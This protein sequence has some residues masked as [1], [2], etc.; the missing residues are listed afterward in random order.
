MQSIK[1]IVSVILTGLMLSNFCVAGAE[2][3]EQVISL[4][5]VQDG[6]ITDTYNN[7]LTSYGS[8]TPRVMTAM[9]GD[10][11]VVDSTG[12]IEIDGTNVADANE[13]TFETWISINSNEKST[14]RRLLAIRDLEESSSMS[15]VL[16]SYT[17]SSNTAVL[18]NKLGTK[19]DP[20][21][22]AD[23]WI[24][25]ST[26]DI[27]QY[28]GTWRHYVFTRK[29][30]SV[31]SKW[32]TKTYVNGVLASS[33]EEIGTK[34][35]EDGCKLYLGSNTTSVTGLS[36][37]LRCSY[38]AFNVYKKELSAERIAELYNSTKNNYRVPANDMTVETVTPAAGN[39]STEAGK[40]TIKFS[41]FIEPSTLSGNIVFTKENGGTVEGWSASVRDDIFVDITIPKLQHREKY[42]VSVKSGLKSLNQIAATEREFVFTAQKAGMLIDEDF[43]GNEFVV[44]QKSPQISGIKFTS[45]H[46][47]YS[48][49]YIKVG[50]T[51]SGTK[52]LRLSPVELGKSEAIDLL[53][54]DFSEG[55]PVIEFKVRRG[56]DESLEPRMGMLNGVNG[57]YAGIVGKEYSDA[58][59][60]ADGFASYKVIIKKNSAGYYQ[61]EVYYTSNGVEKMQEVKFDHKMITSIS[62]YNIVQF[63]QPS[64]TISPENY[65]DI[66][67]IGHYILNEPKVTESNLTTFNTESDDTVTV[68][69]NDKIKE[70]SISADTVKLINK[71]TNKV[72]PWTFVSYNAQTKI[73]TFKVDKAYL[74]YATEYEIDCFGTQ[75]EDGIKNATSTKTT[76]ETPSLDVTLSAISCTYPSFSATVDSTKATEVKFIAVLYDLNSRAVEVKEDT[77]TL[78]APGSD[79]ASITMNYPSVKSGYKLKVIA[80]ENDNGNLKPIKKIPLEYFVE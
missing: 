63:Y 15:E 31:N 7:T 29:W 2:G 59:K 67:Y 53:F 5:F 50:K 55:F 25:H 36:K 26:D 69:F 62:V 27:Y 57:T 47:N 78:T 19:A 61:Y 23:G 28:A 37:G 12:A 4:Q 39:I 48:S 79:T 51:D 24:E 65:I 77:V 73:A 60:D 6:T 17:S 44:G 14:A 68:T 11:V 70:D 22:D 72:I 58:D 75:T 76:F 71:E 34:L 66:S 49:E 10:K 21:T 54:S 33:A 1:K 8:L 32:I 56:G 41:N 30:D 45:K 18:K 46:V 64:G 20:N 16:Y 80:V 9:S 74:E 3:D 40:I 52:Y 35:S 42:K 38:G 43:Q 13:I